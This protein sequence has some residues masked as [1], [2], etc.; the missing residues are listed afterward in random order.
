MKE[1]LHRLTPR[2]AKGR[3]KHKLFQRL[4]DDIGSPRLREH[5]ASVVALM[6]ASDDWDQFMRS[7]NRALPKWTANLKFTFE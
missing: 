5:L 6:K 3:L 4:T 2:D 7:L 1:E